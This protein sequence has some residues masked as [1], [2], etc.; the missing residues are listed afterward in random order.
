[1]VTHRIHQGLNTAS[2]TAQ[3]MWSHAD[4]FVT[5]MAGRMALLLLSLSTTSLKHSDILCGTTQMELGMLMQCLLKVNYKRH[6]L[7]LMC[8]RYICRRTPSLQQDD[9]SL[10]VW[11]DCTAIVLGANPALLEVPL[12]DQQ[13]AV[14][15][16]SC[17]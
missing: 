17:A 5:A 1:V 7:D 3:D 14:L 13:G 9:D 11:R 2:F 10:Q 4:G 6:A 15:R 8:E 16:C 12:A